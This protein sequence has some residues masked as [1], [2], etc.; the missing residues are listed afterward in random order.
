M[1]SDLVRNKIEKK[2]NYPKKPAYTAEE[3]SEFQDKWMKEYPKSYKVYSWLFHWECKIGRFMEIPRN[4]KYYLKNRFI[5]RTHLINTKLA[6]GQWWDSDSKILYGM[7][8]VLQDYVTNEKALEKINWDAT[9]EHKNIK[10]EMIEILNWWNNYQDRLDS[11]DKLLAEVTF[12]HENVMKNFT[13]ESLEREKD[14]FN[15][16][17]EAEA[18]L[19]AE[20]TEML[21]R[22]IKIRKYLWT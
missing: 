9:P 4:I 10:M 21:I 6:P 1:L 19:E 18:K 5:R 13:K 20:E 14:K 11:N 17:S 22:L 7:M 8:N 2:L 3:S 16:H 12:D 15:A